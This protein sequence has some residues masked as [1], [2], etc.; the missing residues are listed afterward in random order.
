MSGGTNADSSRQLARAIGRMRPSALF[1]DEL[2][3]AAVAEFGSDGAWLLLSIVSYGWRSYFDVAVSAVSGQRPAPDPGRPTGY[4]DDFQIVLDLQVQGLVFAATEQLATLIAAARAHRPRSTRFFETYTSPEIGA[5][6][7]MVRSIQ[8]L[9]VSELESLAGVPASESDVADVAG[10]V[11]SLPS[12]DPADMPVVDI[13]GLLVPAS[14]VE[15]RLHAR[16]LDT[17]RRAAEGFLVSI[18]QLLPLVD[19][20]VGAPDVPRPQPLREIDNAYRHGHRVFFYDAVPDDRPF[21][22]LGDLEALEHPAVDLFMPRERDRNI[23]WGTVGCS[24]GRTADSV[25]SLRELAQ[26]IHLFA[27]GFLGRQ[28]GR[29][30]SF[31]ILASLHEPPPLPS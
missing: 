7:P 29:A 2:R 10:A 9:S 3:S 23:S 18:G 19:R 15:E 17:A 4:E 1:S 11:R 21:N 30:S 13:G 31:W 22:F 25:R 24:R 20:P 28:C 8:D 12:L 6:G 16:T 14:S 26:C 5:V 27:L